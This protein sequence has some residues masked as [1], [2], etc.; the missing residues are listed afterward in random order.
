[1]EYKF[2]RAVN[3]SIFLEDPSVKINNLPPNR[4]KYGSLTA[5]DLKIRFSMFSTIML[6]FSCCLLYICGTIA[7]EIEFK[8]HS[9]F[10]QEQLNEAE[11]ATLLSQ[12]DPRKKL[13]TRRR[14]SIVG[15][16]SV[17]PADFNI[18]D[19]PEKMKINKIN[20]KFLRKHGSINYPG[21]PM[22][23]FTVNRGSNQLQYQPRS[24]ALSTPGSNWTVA[25]DSVHHLE[26]MTPVISYKNFTYS[27]N[28]RLGTTFSFNRKSFKRNST[29]RASGR[30]SSF[31]PC[32][33]NQIEEFDGFKVVVDSSE[34][35]SV[36]KTS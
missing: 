19:N 5:L 34:E 35:T 10:I 36:S 8:K 7:E 11:R 23:N 17:D 3:Q 27:P 12:L 18:S 14:G 2:Q 22:Q 30:I 6:C 16:L 24:P 26:A 33:N 1:M 32:K 13:M 15:N 4:S 28:K 20:L 9:E 29:K 25:P 31:Q 21:M